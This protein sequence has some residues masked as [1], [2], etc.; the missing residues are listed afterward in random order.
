MS[1]TEYT[2]TPNL[3]L[4]KPNYDMDDG[5]WGY[6]LNSNADTLDGVLAPV[7][8]RFLPIAGG[9][10]T[11]PITL[12]ADPLSDMQAATKHYVD[13]KAGTGPGG[14]NVSNS[15][16][17][18]SGQAALWTSSTVIQGVN[19]GDLT[20]SAGTLKVTGL[21][22]AAVSATTPTTNQVLTYTGSQ[23]APTAAGGFTGGTVPNTTTFT[24]PGSAL[25]VNN[26]TL[27]GAAGG[28]YFQIVGGTLATD[29]ATLQTVGTGGITFGASKLTGSGAVSFTG[30]G[31]ALTVTNNAS[32][33]GTLTVGG[34][35]SL[36][37]NSIQ[38]AALPSE[39]QQVPVAF[40]FSGNPALNARVNVPVTMAMTEPG[41]TG[42][43]TKLYATTAPT[44]APVFA[45]YRVLGG[46]G[47]PVS[48][49]TITWTAASQNSA[50]FAGAGAS[51]AAGDVL[52]LVCT[53][54]DA[55]IADV[56]ITIQC[57]RV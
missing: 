18:T 3:G 11:G 32:V 10:M 1:G 16:T 34:A 22:G 55:A 54:A 53:T 8:G 50:T 35:V 37:N 39:V 38:Y 4:Y 40:A 23:W 45:L 30:A 57:Q 14:G 9:T 44:G 29:P 7:G 26:N 25:I 20:N 13:T 19:L 24:A 49:G 6:H 36:P 17:P 12:A 15:G 46:T 42:A 41:L 28:N 2:Q 48:I 31:T 5:Q 51:L 21:Q 43:N 52:Q 56:G 27:L 33:G 47:A